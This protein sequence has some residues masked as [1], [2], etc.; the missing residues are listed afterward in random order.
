M[1]EVARQKKSQDPLALDLRDLDF[2]W[3]YLVL[4]TSTSPPQTQAIVDA[5]L[6]VSKEE[7]FGVH[8]IEQ[9][10]EG[11]W[12]LIDYF[13]VVFHIFSE[14]KRSFYKLE[15]LFKNAKKLRFRFRK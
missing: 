4:V 6:K 12:V 9:D 3:D 2:I 10:A 8:H 14:E 15:R 11:G 5:L 1:L 13:D 7:N